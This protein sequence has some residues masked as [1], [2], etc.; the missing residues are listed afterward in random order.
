MDQQEIQIPLPVVGMTLRG[1]SVGGVCTTVQ[2][3]E[4]RLCVDCG[5]LTPT[6]VRMPFLALTHGHA[7]HA[8]ALAS[9]L[10]YRLLLGMG[11]ATVFAPGQILEPL[12]RI[13][14]A[15]EE[16]Q[17]RPFEATLCVASPGVDL[18]LRGELFLRPFETRHTVP[19]V[20]YTLARKRQIL[21]EEYRDHTGTA[22]AKLRKAGVAV[23][24]TADDPLVCFAW[25]G[26]PGAMASDDFARRA[27]VIVTELSF[28]GGRPRSDLAA[29]RAGLH[30]HID[31]L[32]TALPHLECE[33]L[34]LMHLSRKHTVEEAEARILERF[35][36]EWHDR[37]LLMHHQDRK[38]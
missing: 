24:E 11:H 25:D 13:L 33:I 35:P 9:Y 7:D 12:S 15:W 17:E 38:A 10:S 2:V 16:M 30:A 5:I 8:G 3:P 37:V 29:A 23:T 36:P 34:V 28:V 20:G 1:V 22:I 31:E 19:S 21:R 14:S 6:A 27:R 32:L 18:A 4:A 26:T